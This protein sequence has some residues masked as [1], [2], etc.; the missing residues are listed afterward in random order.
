MSSSLDAAFAEFLSEVH[1]D[2]AQDGGS[3]AGD[4]L[5]AGVQD[6]HTPEARAEGPAMK[7]AR[8]ERGCA[9]QAE[10]LRKAAYLGDLAGVKML[11]QRLSIAERLLLVDSADEEDGFA[12]LHLAIIG[13]HV[14]V[15]GALLRG[16]ADV[17]VASRAGD[18]PLMWAAHRGDTAAC[19]ELLRAGA[20]AGL[21]NR[22]GATAA[23]QACGMGHRRLQELLEGRGTGRARDA[24]EARRCANA[25]AVEAAVEEQRQRQEEEAFWAGIRLRREG[26]EAARA[27]Q[28]NGAAGHARARPGPW[29]AAEVAAAALSALPALVRPHYRVLGLPADAT[30][31]DV[32]RRY[33]KLALQHHPDKNR[34]DAAA[35]KERFTELALAYEAVC[36]HLERQEAPRGACVPPPRS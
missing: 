26:R 4:L 24:A 16:R 20:E 19:E 8:P 12:A 2:I 29:A 28:S 13:G 22:R 17:D 11:L 21:A 36:E 34:E 10:A 5:V 9:E 18:T 23:Q 32:R 30:Q 31:S 14:A 15:A 35:A 6:E 25:A 33:R 3:N 27:G 7:R 1:A